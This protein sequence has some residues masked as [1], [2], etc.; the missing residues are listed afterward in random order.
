MIIHVLMTENTMLISDLLI[1][2][3][4]CFVQT[5]YEQVSSALTMLP[6]LSE[7]E[8]SGTHWASLPV[9]EKG[10]HKGPG[11]MWQRPSF[12]P[13]LPL[14]A[15]RDEYFEHFSDFGFNDFAFGF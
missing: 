9:H 1:C 5:F 15:P 8:L 10:A 12:S 3:F 11:R 13:A 2:L 14:V 7:F 6:E 4:L